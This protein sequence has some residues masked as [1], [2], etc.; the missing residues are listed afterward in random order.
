M[1]G[2]GLAPLGTALMKNAAECGQTTGWF[3]QFHFLP[4]PFR[5]R[6]TYLIIIQFVTFVF[7]ASPARSQTPGDLLER[8]N[9]IENR[10]GALQ[11]QAASEEV[12]EATKMYDLGQLYYT[13]RSSTPKKTSFTGWFRWVWIIAAFIQS[14]RDFAFRGRRGRIAVED[15]TTPGESRSVVD[16][17]NGRGGGTLSG[18]GLLSQSGRG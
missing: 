7:A 12:P 2:M 16:R 14:E 13:E 1:C 5:V 4:C 17:S 8:L 9:R 11:I 3:M 15:W 10:L 18:S 6:R